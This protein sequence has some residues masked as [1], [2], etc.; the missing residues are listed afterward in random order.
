MPTAQLAGVRNWQ[1]TMRALGVPVT[2]SARCTYR[3]LLFDIAHNRITD[4][5]YTGTEHIQTSHEVSGGD[6]IVRIIRPPKLANVVIDRIRRFN[7]PLYYIPAHYAPNPCIATY[8]EMARMLN[9]TQ[10]RDFDIT[11]LFQIRID[12]PFEVR[13]PSEKFDMLFNKKMDLDILEELA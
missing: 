3:E 6:T 10:Y 7:M 12:T 2:G 9:I 8:D 5:C 11:T 4:P 1:Q 13:E